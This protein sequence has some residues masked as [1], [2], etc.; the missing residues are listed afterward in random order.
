MTD[1]EVAAKAGHTPT[2]WVMIHDTYDDEL[3]IT[4][5][6]RL[7]ND[8][9]QIA[10]VT[11]NYR[12]DFEAEQQAN[13]SFIVKAVNCHEELV[14]A[15]DEVMTWIR[16]WDSQLADDPEWFDAAAKVKSVLEKAK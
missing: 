14:A 6:T 3:H 2:P 1:N 16:N 10:A 5:Q 15:L 4:T 12:E 13:A 8:K 11:I 9:V 7:D